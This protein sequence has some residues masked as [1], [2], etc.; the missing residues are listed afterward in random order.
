[1]QKLILLI[2]VHFLCELSIWAEEP[3]QQAE[4]Y[5]SAALYEEAVPLYKQA[6]P[7]DGVFRAHYADALIRSGDH[8]AAIS[9]LE[10]LAEKTPEEMFCLGMAYSKSENQEKA[11]AIL[12]KLLG[13]KWS[14]YPDSDRVRYQLALTLS[15]LHRLDAAKGHLTILAASANASIRHLALLA[16]ARAA[17]LEG[18]PEEASRQLETLD[19]VLSK[20]NLLTYEVAYLQGKAAWAKRNWRAAAA[21]FEHALP[22]RNVHLAEWYP[23][24]LY[25]LGCCYLKIAQSEEE[26]KKAEEVL[27]QLLR[28]QSSERAAL[29]LGQCYLVKAALMDDLAAYQA[30][31]RILSDTTR[32]PTSEGRAQA[33]LLRAQAAPHYQDR[34][35]LYLLLTD[36][37]HAGQADYGQSWYLR[38][39]ND[40][41]EHMWESSAS[42]L[43]KA[44]ELLLPL[45]K[46]LAGRARLFQ[47]QALAQIGT[48]EAKQEA[49]DLLHHLIQSPLLEKMEFPD[50]T[51]YLRGLIALHLGDYSQTI[52]TLQEG[53]KNYPQG[54]FAGQSALLLGKTL[55]S[56]QEYEKAEEVFQQLIASQAESSETAEAWFW[57]AQCAEK[58]GASAKMQERLRMVYEKFPHLPLAAEAFFQVYSYRDYLQGERQAVKHLTAFDQYFPDSPYTILANYLIG[59]DAKR[60][61][62]TP[63]GKW[64]RRKNWLEA[65][66]SFQEA[67]ERYDRLLA[68]KK[69]PKDK[70]VYWEN[71]RNQ[72]ALEKAL[73]NL[74]IADES[75]GAKRKIYLEYAEEVFQKLLELSSQNLS[76]NQECCFGLAQVYLKGDQNDKAEEV[77]KR[78]L[79]PDY[80]HGEGYFT[81]R[82]WYELGLLALHD[83]RYAEALAN[84]MQAEKNAPIGAL[85]TDQKL[86]LWIQQSFAYRGL[87]QMDQALLTLSKAV[88]DDAISGLRLKAMYLRAEIYAEQGRHDLA[89]KQLEST[90]KKGGEWGQ[91]AKEKMEKDYGYQ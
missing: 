46:P 74:S 70:L 77:L 87:K 83:N 4:E 59:L 88:N 5:Y 33:L 78:L 35:S 81:S 15:R 44:Y 23:D 28:L 19:R 14:G 16:L 32:F 41:D 42:A 43:S 48:V 73:A 21:A 24:T 1:M 22:Q 57:M 29:A 12:E 20:D 72:A 68:E 31:E 58:Q 91:K 8:A 67:E 37:A 53:L 65:I 80:A 76:Y 79:D 7:L 13:S 3:L 11:V 90:A 50:E 47:A 9:Y 64:I 56:R 25:H 61:R 62:K 75:Q 6:W 26:V 30:A 84:F 27:Q 10:T 63:E 85:T 60:D 17:L 89:R 71:V 38:G 54:N 18:N 2:L 34:A 55:Y 69:L 40:Y 51:Y 86:D 49:L 82:A 66:A 36:S 39:M 45:D 52:R